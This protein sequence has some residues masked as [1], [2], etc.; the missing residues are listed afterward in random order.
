MCFFRA[1]APRAREGLIP[2]DLESD[3]RPWFGR[4]DGDNLADIVSWRSRCFRNTD[5]WVGGTCESCP[6]GQI[7]A[8]LNIQRKVGIISYI[9]GVGKGVS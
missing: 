1:P 9:E 3:E 8:E 2:C 5:A 7:V 6:C 4:G